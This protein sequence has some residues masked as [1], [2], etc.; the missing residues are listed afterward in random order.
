VFK[1]DADRRDR[2]IGPFRRWGEFTPPRCFLRLDAGETVEDQT[3][4]AHILGEA[5]AVWQGIARQLSQAF[6]M[7]LPVIG[8][9]QAAEVTGLI[10]HE[11][12]LARVARL[13]AAVV[14]LLVL[15]IG[16][17]VDRS[18]RAI[19]PTRGG[20][21][22]PPSRTSRQTRRL[23]GPEAALGLLKPDSTRDA[24]RE[25]MCSHAIGSSQRAVLAL[26]E[27]DAVSHLSA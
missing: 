25:S 26:L 15:G 24:V 16:G 23:F 7:R 1:T 2:T 8:G 27:W 10:E 17:A 11:E 14:V 21:T 6:I 5:T 4:D 3:L 18:R 22:S 9:T 19:M 12:V 20:W 13:L